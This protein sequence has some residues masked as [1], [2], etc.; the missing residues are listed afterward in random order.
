MRYHLPGGGQLNP[1]VNPY[2]RIALGAIGSSYIAPKV[3]NRFVR[4]ELNEMDEMINNTTAIGITAIGTV[5][6]FVVLGMVAGKSAAGAV[7]GAAAGGAV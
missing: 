7:A 6:V 5:L 1:L 4:P 2:V 3:I